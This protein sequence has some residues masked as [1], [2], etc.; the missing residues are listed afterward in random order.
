MAGVLN[1]RDF[2]KT[3]G[4]SATSLALPGLARSVNATAKGRQPNILLV[5]TDQQTLGAMSAYGNK[6]VHTP[7][8]DSIAANGVLFEQSYC[9][10]PVC[11]PARSSL[12]TGRMPHETGVNVN[13]QSIHSSIPNMGEIFREMDYETAWAGKWHLPK[14]YPKEKTIPG[15]DYLRVSEDVRFA[16]GSE[17]DDPVA[18]LGIEFL[19]KKHDRPFLLGVSLHNPH[20]ICWW[21]PEMKGTY[22]SKT[23][24]DYPDPD[25]CPPLPSNFDVDPNE[26]EF[27]KICRRRTYYGQQV[28]Y[29]TN[30]DKN[31]WR[32]YIYAYY[33]LVEQVDKSIGRV[34]TALRSAGLEENTLIIFTSDHGEGMAAHQWVVKLMLYEEPVTVPLVISWKGVTPANVVDRDHLVSA[35]DIFPTMCDYAGAEPPRGVNGISLRPLTENPKL[36]GRDFVVSELQPAPKRLEM[37]GRM[38]RTRRYK[39]IAFSEGLNPEMLFDLDSDPGETKNLAYNQALQDELRNH[40]ILLK[41]WVKQTKDVFKM[42]SSGCESGYKSI[43]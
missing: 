11:S 4:L 39:Y 17:T 43:K 33:R 5:I 34:L 12:V 6:Y 16:F 20:D 36:A 14:S 24:F 2:L 10:S 22:F 37:K 8:M 18:D 7:H 26:P 9:T 3:V 1:R 28:S 29:T 31:R 35:L 41:Q 27:I 32:R 40:R 38:L 19:R 25:S 21:F 13:G 23:S 42:P 15:F 30:W